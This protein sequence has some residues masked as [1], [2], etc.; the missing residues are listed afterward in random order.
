M[1]SSY[2]FDLG[3]GGIKLALPIKS[4]SQISNDQVMTLHEIY[5][6]QNFILQNKGVNY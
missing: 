2:P 6:T 1:F 3:E 4:L 5:V